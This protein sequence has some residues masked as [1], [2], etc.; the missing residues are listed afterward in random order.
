MIIID[1]QLSL[2]MISYP[3]ALRAVP[4]PCWGQRAG[5]EKGSGDRSGTERRQSCKAVAYWSARGGGTILS[6]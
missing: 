6:S 2:Y 3:E 1:A 5:S 4:P